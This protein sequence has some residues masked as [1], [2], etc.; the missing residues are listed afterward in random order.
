MKDVIIIGAGIAGLSAG[1]ELL[2]ENIDFQILEISNRVGG[3]LETKSIDDYL[4]ETGPYTFTSQNKD[5][6]QLINE[7]E[8][9]DEII[10]ANSASKKRYIYSQ[11]KLIPFPMNLKELYKTELLSKEGKKT[12]LEEVLISRVEKEETVE[13]FFTR[14][15]GMEVLKN[16]VQPFLCGVFAGDVKKLSIDSVFPK[17]KEL[18]KKHKSILLGF[19]LTK[20]F[21]FKKESHTIYSFKKGMECLPKMIYE[22]I[23]NKVTLSAKNI[24]ITRAKDF[25]VVSFVVNN[26]PIT[27]T[28][29][30]VL[31]AIPAYEVLN[32]THLFPDKN[33]MELFNTEYMPVATVAQSINKSKLKFEA[34]GFGFLCTKE[35]HR[36]LLGTI[37][38]SAIFPGRSKNPDK[39]LLSS[40]IGGNY[41][42]KITD[43]TKEEIES[44]VKKEL[45]EIMEI[46]KEESI[47]TINI[48]LHERAIP[49]YYIG[50]GAKVKKIED[51]M[52]KDFGLFFTGNYL[53]GIS[54][55][56]TIK[57]SKIIANKISDF[58]KKIKQQNVIPEEV[59][60]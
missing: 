58:L 12:L 20:A 2:K 22:K 1:F 47:K 49:Q 13:E 10:E 37:W 31:F 9:K 29:N 26:K 42:K 18:E 53:Y 54:I 51:I 11:K 16:I 21:Q 23:K 48:Q 40:F 28:A 45:C 52:D 57:T 46:T 17:L 56:D 4:I 38:T 35:P 7:L 44:Q 5:I 19:T 43:L 39:V 15:F 36:K 33:V 24:E 6:F 32:Y 27:Y 50:H 25:F 59:K 41:F 34:D 60:I 30:S 3:Y 14:R 8:I 55:N